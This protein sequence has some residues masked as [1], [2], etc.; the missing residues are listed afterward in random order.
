V[1]HLTSPSKIDPQVTN[2]AQEGWS[3]LKDFEKEAIRLLLSFEK[4][5][6]LQAVRQLNQKG[7]AISH[8]YIFPNISERTGFVH[9]VDP[10][11]QYTTEYIGRWEVTPKFQAVLKIIAEKKP[12]T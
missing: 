4:L 8:L 6:C 3:K 5:T 11:S 10:P 12:S 1:E 2:L 7:L 9:R